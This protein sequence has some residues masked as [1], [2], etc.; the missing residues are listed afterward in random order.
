WFGGPALAQSAGNIV[1][2][3]AARLVVDSLNYGGVVDPWA[4]EG[5]Q[6]ASPGDGC[7]VASPG[8][9]RGRGGRAASNRSAGRYPDGADTD[10]NCEDF[11]LQTTS[12]LAADAAAGADNIKVTSADFSVGQTVIIDTGTDR[13]TAVIATVGTP[14]G[15]LVTTGTDGGATVVP[16]SSVEGFGPGQ[17]ITIDSGA[18][19]ETATVASVNGGRRRGGRGGASVTVSAPL[20]LAHAMGAQVSGSGIT[21]KSPLTKAHEIGAQI[22]GN[23]PT[24]GAPNQYA[25]RDE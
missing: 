24:P 1:L 2:R 20:K 21:F 18:N 17:T 9:G 3:N 8:A 4:A 22:S 14:G 25:K 16:V 12:A 11:R 13:E 19:Q 7:S 5:Y 6:G 10:S 15:T 23:V